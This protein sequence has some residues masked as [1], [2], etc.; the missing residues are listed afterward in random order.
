MTPD[1]VLMSQATVLVRS[2]PKRTGRLRTVGRHSA[3]MTSPAGRRCGRFKIAESEP[4]DGT[5]DSWVTEKY[6]VNHPRT[7]ATASAETRKTHAP[8]SRT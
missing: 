3:A 2:D 1:A 6:V 8:I 7:D 4:L 5:A